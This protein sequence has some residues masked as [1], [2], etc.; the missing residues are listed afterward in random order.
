MDKTKLLQML[1][2]RADAYQA[3][4]PA[5][6]EMDIAIFRDYCAGKSAVGISMDI[7]C[8]EST[9][10]RSIRRVKDFLEEIPILDVLRT[11]IAE[12]TPIYGNW[13]AQSVLEMLYVAY[14]DYN[15]LE[16]E[17]VQHDLRELRSILEHLSP[18]LSEQAFDLLCDLCSKHERS[19]FT[20]GLKLGVRLADE[21]NA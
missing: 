12:C 11:H 13:D 8:A 14:A 9:V 4:H 7:P 17:N 10:Y 5:T 21:L 2:A 20:E 15:A 6:A 19:G 18:T 1:A 16:P 3:S